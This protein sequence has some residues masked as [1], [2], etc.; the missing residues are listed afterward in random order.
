MYAGVGVVLRVGEWNIERGLN[1][2][3]IR[4]AL[5]DPDDFLLATAN[6]NLAS[7]LPEAHAE[8]LIEEKPPSRNWPGCKVLT[9]SSSTKSM[10]A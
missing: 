10:W 5:S 7:T 8:V 3:L 2:D 9:F 4:A 1:F 6:Q